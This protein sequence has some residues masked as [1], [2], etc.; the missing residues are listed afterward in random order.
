MQTIED[1]ID[2]IILAVVLIAGI[3]GIVILFWDVVF[4]AIAGEEEGDDN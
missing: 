2:S 4:P 3:Y 1:I